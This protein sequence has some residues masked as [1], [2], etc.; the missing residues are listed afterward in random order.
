MLDLRRDAT[1]S[2]E[3]ATLAWE[4]R[5]AAA[6]EVVQLQAVL[7][8]Q[9]TRFEAQWLELERHATAERSRRA[10]QVRLYWIIF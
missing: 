2:T 9:Q 5:D 7:T 10:A 6:K 1:R 8:A 3:A 4:A